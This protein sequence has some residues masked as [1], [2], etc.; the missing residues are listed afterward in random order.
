VELKETIRLDTEITTELR[1]EGILREVTR[2]IQEIR[3]ELGLK[4]K[5]KIIIQFSASEKL[6]DILNRNKKF[7][8]TTTKAKDLKFLGDVREISGTKKEIKV[9]DERLY[10]GITRI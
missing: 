6:I 5:D 8:L 3:K 4:P 10:L 2:H 1:E 9:D 7:I